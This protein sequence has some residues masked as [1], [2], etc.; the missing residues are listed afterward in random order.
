VDADMTLHEVMRFLSQE[1]VVLESAAGPVA[2]LASLVAA[3]PIRGSWW[4]H[5]RAREIFALTRAVREHDDVLAC[6]LVQGKVTFVHRRLWPALVSAAAHFPPERL[7]QIREV[8]EPSG[9]HVAHE[10]PFPEWVPAAVRAAADSLD[11]EEALRA[12]GDWAI[13]PRA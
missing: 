2:S 13:E 9:R 6:R 12:L 8:H 5:P 11:E 4:S 1:G 10:V 3:G 7:A